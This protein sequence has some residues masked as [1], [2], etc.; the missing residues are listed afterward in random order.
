MTSEEL[1]QELNK[2]NIT[3]ETI[4]EYIKFEDE[5]IRLGFTFN[6][7][8]KGREKQIPKKPVIKLGVKSIDFIEYEDGHGE[9][10][11]KIEN[12]YEC[13]ECGGYITNL[14]QI[15]GENVPCKKQRY[16]SKCGQKLDWSE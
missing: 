4:E 9:A 16:C 11:P 2:R 1:T 3:I 15:R 8:I 7:V 12:K 5:C 6:S 10:K 14:L 13:P